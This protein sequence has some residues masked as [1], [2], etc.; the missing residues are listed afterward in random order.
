[1]TS[2]LMLSAG[3]ALALTIAAMTV[4]RPIAYR[5]DL[6]DRP[7]GH[8]THNGAVPVVGGLAMLLGIVFGLALQPG[9]LA[10]LG[11]FLVSATLLVVVGLFD[12]RFTL[13]PR[14]R[15]AAQ[16]VA[17]LPMVLGA[18]IYMQDFGDLFGTGPLTLA[19]GNL[20][21]T[22]FVTMAAINAFNMLDGL[23]GL[24]GGLTLIALLAFLA[25]GAGALSP[26]EFTLVAVIA[27][28]VVGFL[29]FN[30]P[31][32]V[33]RRIRCFMG[34][35][36]STLLGFSI[37]WIAIAVS[38]RPDASVS[39]VTTV[40]FVAVPATDLLWTV[41][42]RL[43]RGQSPLR[44]DNEHLHHLLLRAGFGVRAVFLTMFSTG[45][46]TAVVGLVLRHVDAPDS[47]SLVALVVAAV[48]IV[49]LYR[50]ARAFLEILP[51]R[52]RRAPDFDHETARLSTRK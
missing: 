32:Q 3:A 17:V 7:G 46:V 14:T 41:G 4:L 30:I 42:R 5:I 48:W 29:V 25:L 47:L 18:G 31:V 10:P 21:V 20:F 1:V 12:D 34:D 36:G 9:L 38:Q 27:G 39:A 22:A 43:A 19:H 44:P 13:S 52:L 51:S 28:A 33:N 2:L 16:F 40:W 8:K 6:L 11:Y 26:G 23:D 15:L 45:A 50:N 24:A 35:A 37:A 49:A